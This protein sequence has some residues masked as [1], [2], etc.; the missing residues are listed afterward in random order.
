MGV[1]LLLAKLSCAQDNE[2]ADWTEAVAGFNGFWV[3]RFQGFRV[4]GFR[5]SGLRAYTVVSR[6][7]RF[8]LPPSAWQANEGYYARQATNAEEKEDTCL[9]FKDIPILPGIQ[10]GEA[11]EDE[12]SLRIVHGYLMIVHSATGL[13]RA[14]PR[15]GGREVTCFLEVWGFLEVYSL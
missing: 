11:D 2:E 15:G 7:L 10:E 6:L 3:F 5:G 4:E 1:G 14:P 13:G 8:S 12:A 9:R